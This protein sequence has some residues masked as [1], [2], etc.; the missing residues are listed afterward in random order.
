[1]RR[2]K[3]VKFIR[4]M[5]L[6]LLPAASSAVFADLILD[7]PIEIGK[8][9]QTRWAQVFAHRFN[10][11][12]SFWEM[13][14]YRKK[15]NPS[16]SRYDSVV[17]L[18]DFRPQGY[19]CR[20]L[21]IDT[22]AWPEGDYV[23]T[24]D[25]SFSISGKVVRKSFP[26]PVAIRRP[27]ATTAQLPAEYDGVASGVMEI[28]L[29]RGFAGNPSGASGVKIPWQS[30]FSRAGDVKATGV[31]QTKF[32]VFHD[33]KWLYLAIVCEE[34]GKL[35]QLYAGKMLPFDSRMIF[36]RD[37][38]EVNVDPEGKGLSFHK[39]VVSPRGEVFDAFMKDDNTG[40]MT[41]TLDR[42]H[43][44]GVKVN[45]LK[46]E[47]SWGVELALPLGPLVGTGAGETWRLSVA[48]ERR[49]QERFARDE[50]TVWP[51]GIKS[52]SSVCEY[53][54]IRLAGFDPADEKM[55][56]SFAGATT[57]RDDEGICLTVN[58]T[59]FNSA[60]DPRIVKIVAYLSDANGTVLHR[61]ESPLAGCGSKKRLTKKLTFRNLK[62][63]SA[64][65]HLEAYSAEGRLERHIAENIFVEYSPVKVRFTEPFY[66]D[67]F[68]DS[69]DVSRVT[70]EV[71]LKEG[72]GRPLEIALS[73]PDTDERIC[74]ASASAT[75]SFEFPFVGK[76][77]GDYFVQVG[78]CR[79]RIR[80]LP[81]HEGE[82]WLDP[83]GVAYRNGKKFLPFGF[84]EDNFREDYPGLTIAQT[85]RND[86][87]DAKQLAALAAKSG[88]HGRVLVV[89]VQQRFGTDGK[90]A[91][92]T[93]DTM[94]GR[95]TDAEREMLDLYVSAVKNMP[96]FGMYYLCDEPSGRDLNPDWFRD[97]RR[98]L[99]EKDPYHPTI[100]LDYSIEGTIR[101]ADCADINCPD[102]YPVYCTDGTTRD[103]RRLTY[104]F[105]L[106]ASR[107]RSAWMCPQYFDWPTYGN[108]KQTCG[109]TY[110]DLRMQTFLAL[111]GGVKGFMCFTR[112]TFCSTYN[113]HLTLGPARIL[114]EIRE[115]QDL[116]LASS[117]P[118][119]SKSSGPERTFVAVS[120]SF[121]G[122][123][124]IIACNTADEPV[125]A[126]FSGVGWKT[127]YPNGIDKP[128]SA[129]DGMFTDAFRANEVKIY[130]D[131]VRSFRP[132]AIRREIIAAEA[133][134]INPKNL[135]AAKKT[136]N[137]SELRALG[138]KGGPVEWYPRL[139]ASSSMGMKE[140]TYM[141]YFLQDGMKGARLV[142]PALSWMPD[143][144][145][146]N[147]KSHWVRI[148]F[149]DKSKVSKIVVYR[150][151]GDDGKPN[152]VNGH[153]EANG[154]IVAE[155][156]D[157]KLSVLELEFPEIETAE[158]TL[159]AGKKV[160]W[161]YVSRW[162]TEI[163]A[164]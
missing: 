58:A 72:V 68:Y 45:P 26:V 124:L 103:S 109:P 149:G 71:V 118:I 95:L 28:P 81:R 74:I 113:Q 122:E 155:F 76:K 11:P 110:D 5:V 161:D 79:K 144:G 148:E 157:D 107:S 135:V 62:S 99:D 126:S 20:T 18:P 59:L 112:T 4:L 67:S 7:S 27:A 22:S 49:A 29:V 82:I 52:F 163:E 13:D 46:M 120:K 105:A 53:A 21:P 129:V 35:E 50:E 100:I 158:I 3:F 101:Y 77:K 128:M 65:L 16:D 47:H 133:M 30:G 111:A 31:A 127:A 160:R 90:K 114:E 73:G 94:R 138:K 102:V 42:R 151:F 36:N 39:I 132:D 40:T 69:M 119:V 51:A 91:V 93:A 37:Y 38:V 121:G 12:K 60:P 78:T 137:L 125:T 164:Y 48:R 56:F 143:R 115:A 106:A 98:Y 108:G 162:I 25:G 104:D 14:L 139:S 66:R 134:R 32:K 44:S 131:R 89:P 63:R 64:V 97:V 152:L 84:F 140:K 156:D 83:A 142:T 8:G 54:K 55:A 130:H 34:P 6:G 75:N 85:Y 1:M 86:F 159:Y 9:C 154:Q 96:W 147:D 57:A 153:I 88:A 145:G 141:P 15:K 43:A 23:L 146:G 116:Y 2:W 19:P 117:M 136:L 123:R 150:A 92:M 17:F 70:G 10:L 61:T 80:N 87:T 41:Y 24:F 33:G